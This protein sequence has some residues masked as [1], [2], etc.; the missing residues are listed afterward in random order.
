MNEPHDKRFHSDGADPDPHERALVEVPAPD[1]SQSPYGSGASDVLEPRKRQPPPERKGRRP[2][3]TTIVKQRSALS[4][5]ALFTGIILVILVLGVCL[6]SIAVTQGVRGFMGDTWSFF[7]DLL[8]FGGDSEPEV[9]D[10]T[11]I[12]LGIKELAFL[13]TVSGDVM[14]EKTVVQ[15]KT[16]VLKDAK[17][18]I[19]YVGRVTAGIDLSLIT[20]ED[21]TVQADNTLVVSLPPVQYSGCYLQNPEILSST[22]GTNFLG[23]GDCSDTFK[24]MQETAHERAIKELLETAEKLELLDQAY[25]NAEQAVY[26]LLHNMGYNDVQFVRSEESLP[27]NESCVTP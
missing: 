6:W 15:E 10:T 23:L 25:Q 12:V 5:C 24:R 16:S 14:I 18:R 2:P 9:V 7:E 20:V 21:I 27:P 26:G 3:P 22:C 13:E 4:T 17:L 1:L 19:R 11:V 8:G